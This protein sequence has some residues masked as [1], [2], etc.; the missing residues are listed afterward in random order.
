MLNIYIETYGCSANQNNGEIIAG[1]LART[2]FNIVKNKALADIAILNSLGFFFMGFIGRRVIDGE[3][4][5]LLIS[6]KA[7]RAEHI[8]FLHP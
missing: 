7:E 6:V 3:M 8:P 5:V 1:L 2:G 4:E